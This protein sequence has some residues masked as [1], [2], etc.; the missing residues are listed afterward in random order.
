MNF[1]QLVAA[2]NEAG[3]ALTMAEAH[4]LSVASLPDAMINNDGVVIEELVEDEKN[5]LRQTLDEGVLQLEGNGFKVTGHL[6]FGEP[7]GEIC[8]LASEFQ[9]DLI[10][11]GHTKKTKFW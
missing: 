8:R 9:C 5:R 3:M 1:D 11:V 10:V 7:V 2:M 6:A 4:L